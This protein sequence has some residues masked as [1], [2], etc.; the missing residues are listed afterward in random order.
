MFDRQYTYQ[1]SAT[2]DLA[3]R[4]LGQLRGSGG[5]GHDMEC[6]DLPPLKSSLGA[7]VAPA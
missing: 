4:S 1:V 5:N 3:R 6:H 7:P 2:T